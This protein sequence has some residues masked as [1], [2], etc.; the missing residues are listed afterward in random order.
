MLAANEAV[1]RHLENLDIPFLYR[2]HERP[3]REDTDQLAKR[4]SHLRVRLPHD[5]ARLEPAHL[6]A[7]VEQARG[8]PFERLVNLMV[9]RAMT[10]ARYDPY[11]QIH[12]GLSSPC[13]THFTSPIRRYPDL[14]V[15]RA[16][17][18]AI[19]AGRDRVPPRSELEATAKHCSE[20]E[21][22]AVEAERDAARAAAIL[23]MQ[24]RIGDEFDGIVTG[25]ERHGFY[26]DL[27]DPFIEGCVPLARLYEYYE[28]VPDR[29]ELCS[30][31]STRKIRV[32]DAMR[33]GVVACEL[34]ERSLELAPVS[35]RP[36][37]GG[38]R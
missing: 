11:K 30:R 1:A 31:T 16:L 15:H 3:D 10:Q 34:A 24:S 18:H 7:A 9:L 36:A 12:F 17:C 6:Q 33:V 5:G 37:H 26:V 38:R 29:M 20:R 19:G 2:I 27:G 35:Q 32:G 4:L 14:V 13:Y 23:C 28:Y 21:R 25:V 8:K 22:R